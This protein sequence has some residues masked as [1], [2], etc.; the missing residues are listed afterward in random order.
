[1]DFT[2]TYSPKLLLRFLF[3]VALAAIFENIYSLVSVSLSATFWIP[4]LWL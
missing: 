2:N 1:M 3:P 4:G